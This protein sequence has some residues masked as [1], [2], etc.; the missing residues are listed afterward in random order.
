M[1]IQP[2]KRYPAP[3]YPTL[4]ETQDEPGLLARVPRRWSDSSRFAVLL[5]G[6]VMLRALLAQA[7]ETSSTTVSTVQQVP[8][9][10]GP[11]TAAQAPTPM[12]QAS[13]V[14]APL[15]AEALEHDGRGSFGCMAVNPP[16]FLSEDEAVELIRSE[17][18]IAGLA[19]EYEVVLNDVPVPNSA[20][21]IVT[22]TK[23]NADGS[24]S[25]S[26]RPRRPDEEMPLIKGPYDFDLAAPK[27][28]IYIEYLSARDHDKWAGYPCSTARSYDFPKLART[29]AGAWEKRKADKPAVIGIFF[30]PL[31]ACE[32]RNY[33]GTSANLEGVD[34]KLV[35]LSQEEAAKAGEEERTHLQDKAKEKLRKQVRNFVAFL[36]QK[37]LLK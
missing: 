13:T 8:E 5:G 26:M 30:D 34:P 20:S 9:K 37:D 11:A 12:Q 10:P 32:E 33:Y 2:V 25:F 7:E 19:L 27:R 28:G 14:V 6:S 31:A 3:V 36:K 23:K 24:E 29:I 35:R 1:K 17:L 15:L 16:T 21:R 18:A 22:E 4:G